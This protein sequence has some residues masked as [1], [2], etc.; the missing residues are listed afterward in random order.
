MMLDPESYIGSLNDTSLDGLIKERNLVMHRLNHYEKHK[1][2]ADEFDLYPAPEK[3]YEWNNII[4]MKLT[5]MIIE[6]HGE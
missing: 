2:N 1:G 5:N 6:R 3:V 4:L